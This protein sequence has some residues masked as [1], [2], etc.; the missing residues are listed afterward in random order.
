MAK[1]KTYEVTGR[2]FG[3]VYVK[4]KS[5]KGARQQYKKRYGSKA[6]IRDVNWY[7]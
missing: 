3:K 1:I 7:K 2:K 4:A 5:E 6:M